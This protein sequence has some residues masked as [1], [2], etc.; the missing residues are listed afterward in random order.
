M[1]DQETSDKIAILRQKVLARTATLDEMKES[2]LYLRQGRL[3]AT[4]RP[5][6][7]PGEAKPKSSKAPT[8]DLDALFAG[9]EA[10]LKGPKT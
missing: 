1:F 10:A 4:V 7:E 9:L 2:I 5:K 8:R 3:T 6:K